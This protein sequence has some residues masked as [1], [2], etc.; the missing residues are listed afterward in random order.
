MLE[1]IKI[2]NRYWQIFDKKFFCQLPSSKVDTA[3]K[4][5]LLFIRERERDTILK[6]FKVYVLF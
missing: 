1:N 5:P 6:G 2:E 4:F 3:H